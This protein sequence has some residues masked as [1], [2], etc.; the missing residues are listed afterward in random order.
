MI[1]INICTHTHNFIISCFRN[2]AKKTRRLL[3][4]AGEIFDL[5]YGPWNNAG[6][7]VLNKLEHLMPLL[8]KINL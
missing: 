3:D 6:S 7:Q 5:N 2:I 4:R 8:E 1:I